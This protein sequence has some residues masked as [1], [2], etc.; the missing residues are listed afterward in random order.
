MGVRISLLA[1]VSAGVLA[2]CGMAFA[3]DESG[4]DR[5]SSTN[6]LPTTFV[7]PGGKILLTLRFS[8]AIYAAV[9]QL[10]KSRTAL[11]A[12]LELYPDE[13]ISRTR[14]LLRKKEHREK[15][16]TA[17]RLAGLPE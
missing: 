2:G 12:L 6:L 17:L 13:S 8:A 4:P 1:S 16:V 7:Y 9:G 14:P 5:G 10:E 11:K 15:V 3:Q